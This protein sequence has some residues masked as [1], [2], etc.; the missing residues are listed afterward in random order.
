LPLVAVEAKV[1]QVAQLLMHQQQLPELQERLA[2]RV[3]FQ[4]QVEQME[5]QELPLMR[6]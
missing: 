3:I 4:V 5:I 1:V 6:P 2:P